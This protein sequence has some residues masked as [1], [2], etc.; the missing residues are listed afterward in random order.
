M[1]DQI[2][3]SLQEAGRLAKAAQGTVWGGV[4]GGLVAALLEGSRFAKNQT[5]KLKKR[6]DD[7]EAAIKELKAQQAVITPVELPGTPSISFTNG[8]FGSGGGTITFAPGSNDRRM[9]MTFNN[10]G[11]AVSSGTKL[12]TVKFGKVFEGAPFVFMQRTGAGGAPTSYSQL[13]PDQAGVASFDIYVD[14][15]VGGQPITTYEIVVDGPRQQPA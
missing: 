7:A 6:L 12:C 1:W 5:D 14:T 13:Y 10:N 3:R 11:N 8:P 2:D 4:L 15:W 9:I